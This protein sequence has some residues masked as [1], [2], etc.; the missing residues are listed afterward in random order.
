MHLEL[1]AQLTRAAGAW[2]PISTSQ[3]RVFHTLMR[4]MPGVWFWKSSIS[5]TSLVP[6]APVS[7]PGMTQTEEQMSS[8]L[9]PTEMKSI[10]TISERYQSYNVEML[11]VTGGK[12]WK[13]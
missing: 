13:P 2:L 1:I 12:F 4:R 5:G 10:G 7:I 9:S 8:R 6:T 3:A 11:E